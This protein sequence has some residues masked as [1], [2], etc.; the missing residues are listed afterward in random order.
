M[1]VVANFFKNLKEIRGD[2]KGWVTRIAEKSK[3]SRATVNQFVNGQGDPSLS[4]IEK[5][6]GALQV[7]VA[8]LLGTEVPVVKEIGPTLAE[9]RLE[10]IQL[11][12]AADADDIGTVIVGLKRNHG[13]IDKGSTA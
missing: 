3:L 6:A 9:L 2:D 10:A 12:L 8:G 13:T 4:S 1:G 11:I 7:P 5:L